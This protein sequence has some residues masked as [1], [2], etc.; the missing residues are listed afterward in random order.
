[1]FEDGLCPEGVDEDLGVL[2]DDR[3]VRNHNDDA[4]HIGKLH[5]PLKSEGHG[6]QGLRS[7]RGNRERE[8]IA[9]APRGR[10]AGFE[11]THSRSLHRTIR[12]LLRALVDEGKQPIK[13]QGG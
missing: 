13:A 9:G 12:N 10:A 2:L 3:K 8:D 7:A 4:A 11:H 1:M 6:T 5:S